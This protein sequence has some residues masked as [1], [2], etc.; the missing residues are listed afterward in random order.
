MNHSFT[1]SAI[2]AFWKMSLLLICFLVI[3][4][5][6]LAEEE[7]DKAV[8]TAPAGTDVFASS[9]E[10]I[11]FVDAE[12]KKRYD[13]LLANVRTLEQ[14]FRRGGVSATE[15]R[16]SISELRKSLAAVRAEIDAKKKL[17]SPFKIVTQKTEGKIEL[18]AERL[19]VVTADRIKIVGWDKPHVKYVMVKKVLSTGKPVDEHLAGM[20]IVHDQKV[21]PDL[22]GKTDAEMKAWRE[23]YLK[24]ENGTEQTPEQ[25]EQ[26]K[27][28]WE[29]HFANP[30]RFQPFVGR[31]VDALH[32]EGLVGGEGN[33]QVW[34]EVT[35][36]EG[37]GRAGSRW[38]R[39]A[40]VTLYVPKC[41]AL[42]L[43][44]C[45]MGLDVSGVNAPLMMTYMG[46][47]HQSYSGT[48]SVRD[49]IGSLTL[50][51]VP[52][53]VIER[54]DGDVAI[55]LTTEMTNTGGHREGT[56]WRLFAPPPRRMQVSAVSGDL[57]VN[58]VHADLHIDKVGG[59]LNIRNDF[60]DTHCSAESTLDDG[61]H[62]IL[63]QDGLVSFEVADETK[64]N[65]PVFAATRCGTAA[66]NFGREE[67]DD[68]NVT[69]T[70]GID[71]QRCDWRSLFTKVPRGDFNA[72]FA[73]Q[74]RPDAILA[75][76][77]RSHG[78]DLISV[79][80]R[81]EYLKK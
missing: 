18:G 75:D 51:N 71:G 12:L 16:S 5:A 8:A 59:L 63:S 11:W 57:K 53:D 7:E 39:S 30:P 79:A 9:F 3:C 27:Q 77:K 10:G 26:K 50:D 33:Q 36:P 78:L 23:N 76:Q 61:N 62:R 41:T 68:L 22:V 42:L 25:L 52:I 65:L 21:A 64:V 43:R 35:S 47:Q 69:Y 58:A 56:D 46:S 34:Y 55:T 29:K 37:N 40:D 38:R 31:E 66:T 73:L 67:L 20:K 49:H 17:V 44:G 28:I 74:Q 19:L 13:S 1:R 48:F 45:Q 15:V 24:P 72:Q 4:E 6:L 32:I 81:V 54:V 14:R 80:G 2:T 70:S 60:G